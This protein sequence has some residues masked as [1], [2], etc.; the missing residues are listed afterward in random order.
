MLR[1]TAPFSAV[2]CLLVL[3]GCM[4]SGGPTATLAEAGGTVTFQ[5]A[6]LAGATVTFV[7]EKGPGAVASG[8]TDLAGKYKLNTGALKGVA[9]GDC[10]V[11]IS[12]YTPGDDK[13]GGEMSMD[14]IGAL[15][16]E[17]R[18]KKLQ[19]ITEARKNM[20]QQSSKPS[21]KPKS[22]IP[23]KYATAATSGLKATVTTDPAKN[24]FDFK[25]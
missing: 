13:P 11:S 10:K 25:L 2:V 20:M 21:E 23:E 18:A 19:E 6:P 22:M 17:E 4:D 7:P 5:N 12:V 8:V 24:V 16:P 3:T 14:E 9:V 15:P 1:Q